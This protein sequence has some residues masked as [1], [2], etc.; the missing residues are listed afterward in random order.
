MKETAVRDPGDS[1][2][3]VSISVV[4]YGND[5]DVQRLLSSLL[6]HEETSLQV[7]VTDNLGDYVAELE[8]SK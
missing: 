1:S 2:L 6:D 7:I 8:L 4:S 5:R 3:R